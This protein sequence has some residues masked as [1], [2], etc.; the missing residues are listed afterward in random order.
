[1]S[2]LWDALDELSFGTVGGAEVSLARALRLLQSDFSGGARLPG[3]WAHYVVERIVLQQAAAEL[4]LDPPEEETEELMRDFR[5]QRNLYS[6]RETERFLAE[7]GLTLDDFAEAMELGWQE[8]ALRHRY[9]EEPAGRHFLLHKADYDAAVLSELVVNDRDLALE[10]LSQLREEGVDF[11]LLV[12]RHST[13]ESRDRA[14]FLGEV[15]RGALRAP[16]AAAVFAA[17][18]DEAEGPLLVVGP[19]PH[20][21][22]FRLLQVHDVRRAVFS[23]ALRAEIA[24]GIWREWLDRRLRGAQPQIFLFQPSVAGD[25]SSG[26]EDDAPG[27]D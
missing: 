18:V 6:A 3:E 4:G 20:G 17:E 5:R 13:A 9:A 8:R 14:G 19:F 23:D 22:K 1:M 27:D 10:L 2:S 7:R 25:R 24:E 26:E 11:A 15:R 12:R 16:E 21:R